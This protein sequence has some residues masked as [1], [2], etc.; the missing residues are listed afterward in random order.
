MPF[1]RAA[2]LM[3]PK[4]RTRTIVQK[5]TLIREIPIQ[6]LNASLDNLCVNNL[7]VIHFSVP[8]I[9]VFHP[10]DPHILKNSFL[11]FST[12]S[13]TVEL[14]TNNTSFLRYVD[15]NLYTNNVTVSLATISKLCVGRIESTEGNEIGGV[16]LR[17]RSLTVPGSAYVGESFVAKEGA[18]G[19]VTFKN[20]RAVFT[21]IDTRVMNTER[22]CV[23]D[24]SCAF[25]VRLGDVGLSGG[26][27]NA[28]TLHVETDSCI[29]GVRIHDCGID[30]DYASI[31]RVSSHRFDIDNL[32]L[33][34]FEDRLTVGGG[35]FTPIQSVNN[36]GC[37]MSDGSSVFIDGKLTA[38]SGTLTSV[39]TESLVVGDVIIDKNSVKA[40]AGLFDSLVAC[41]VHTS[42]IDT[43]GV[44]ASNIHCSRIDTSVIVADDYIGRDGT[45][46]LKNVIPVGMISLFSGEIPPRGWMLCDGRGG[47]PRL[48]SPT[49]GVIYMVRV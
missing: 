40:P 7:S 4:E 20:G 47:R 25:P 44:H 12:D 37:L 34:S 1:N 3:A 11:D 43:S 38:Y 8:D 33:S 9:T 17:N 22:L 26:N 16:F 32:S 49:P 36:L 27:V 42:R 41:N 13:D 6:V 5:E 19:G 18:V 35:I 24:L 30:C 46:I 14:R 15:S 29:S 48:P 23:N 2:L 28:N 39:Q 31:S 10:K 21:Q 45:A